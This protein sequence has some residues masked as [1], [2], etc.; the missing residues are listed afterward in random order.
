MALWYGRHT[1][2]GESAVLILQD[3]PFAKLRV[4]RRWRKFWEFSSKRVGVH[5]SVYEIRVCDCGVRVQSLWV[6]LDM[7]AAVGLLLGTGALG[8]GIDLLIALLDGVCR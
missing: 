3:F 6:G 4:L 5:F 1:Y 2:R 7:G 8:N